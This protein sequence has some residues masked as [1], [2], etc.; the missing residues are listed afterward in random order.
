MSGAEEIKNG[1]PIMFDRV[2]HA[3][4]HTHTVTGDWHRAVL[5]LAGVVERVDT[6][7]TTCGVKPADSA[8]LLLP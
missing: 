1:Q 5:R 8:K 7:H 6:L 4:T 2:M 3:V